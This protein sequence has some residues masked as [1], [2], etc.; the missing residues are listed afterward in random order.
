[1]YRVAS[2]ILAATLGVLFGSTV[3]AQTTQV[4]TPGTPVDPSLQTNGRPV[5]VSGLTQL[6]FVAGS[7]SNGTTLPAQSNKARSEQNGSDVTA[8]V[9]VNPGL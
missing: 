3:L 4:V 2:Y 1:M 8:Q 9:V 5:K 7:T 6:K